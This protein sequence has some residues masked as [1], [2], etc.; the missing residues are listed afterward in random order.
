MKLVIIIPAFNE[1]ATIKKVLRAI[2]TNI[3]KITTIETVVVDDGSTD[4][5][6]KIAKAAGATVISH[7]KNL[8]LGA[9]FR[10]GINY[11]L[12]NHADIMVNIDADGQF[13]PKDIPKLVAP[14]AKHHFDCTIASRFMDK[15]LYP[16][17]NPL[18]FWGNRG[19]SFLISFLTRQKFYDVSCGMRAYNRHALLNFNLTGKFTY[20]QEAILNLTFKGV[21]IKEVPIKVLGT[22]EHGQSKMA[23]NLWRYAIR[24]SMIIFRA[25]RDYK[26]LFFFG[27][28]SLIF[29]LIALALF[30]FLGIH[31]LETKSLFPHKWAGIAG[32]ATSI[33][34]FGCFMV[35]LLADMLDRI[36]MN[37][38][39]I[40]YLLQDK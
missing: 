12:N 1:D 14:I 31:Y 7:V 11:A 32:I 16:Q 4:K 8:G 35:G 39:K 9:T 30:T 5:T 19:M 22:R 37:Q 33:I 28:I 25:F 23:S 34:S 40:I 21:T 20:T 24:S 38:E 3:P 36:R 18:K 15:S 17:M 27:I 6:K 2:P 10:S 29:L 26:P 13:A